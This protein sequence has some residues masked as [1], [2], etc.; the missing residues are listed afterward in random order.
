MHYINDIRDLIGNTPLLKLNHLAPEIEANIFAKLE[1]LN[2]GGSVKD[3]V[4]LEILEAAEKEGKLLPGY[5]I[6]EAT[7]G[8]MGIGLAMAAFEKGYEVKLVVPAKFALE[9]QILMKALG[10]EIII[11]PTEE[12]I[13]GAIRKAKELADTI[14]SSFTPSQFENRHNIYAHFKTGREI[15]EALDGQIDILVAGAGS[16]GTVMGI[17]TYLKAQNPKIK[18]VLADPVGSILGGGEEGSYHIEGIGNH[19]IPSIFDPSVIDEVEKISDEEASYYVQLLGKKEGVLV[20]ASSGAAVAASIKQA[21]KAQ[22][23]VNIVTVLPDRSDR[24]FSQNL[25]DFDLRLSDFRFKALFDNWADA[26]D[27]TIMA[28]TGEYLEVFENYDSI[29]KD[30]VA[31]IHKPEGALVLDLGS[32]TGNLAHQAALAGYRVLGIEP[33]ER[34]RQIAKAKYPS[35]TFLEGTFLNLPHSDEQVDAIISSY[36]FHHLSD[37]EK[38]AAIKLFASKLKNHGKV[39]FADTTYAS[40]EAQKSLLQEA[41]AK[42][43]KSLTRDLKTEF[44]TT[45]QVLEK[46]FKNQGFS[47]QFVQKNKFVW[48]LIATK[49]T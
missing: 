38:G 35:I 46:L 1:Y 14:P 15:Y 34:M 11:T 25:Y 31:A 41:E 26:Y 7:A 33:N 17:A 5:T 28:S 49:E 43:Y 40:V 4:G 6:I 23:T 42:G 32:G 44:Y 18:V 30:T 22:K 13:E 19:F 12:G 29:L 24:Y 21:Y 45:H 27:G 20:G 9:K 48:I 2:P 10:A 16:G 47:I 3:R 8:N 37:Q 39:I 36:A